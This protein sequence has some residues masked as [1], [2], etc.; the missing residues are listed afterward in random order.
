MAKILGTNRNIVLNNSSAE[1]GWGSK[2]LPSRFGS[3]FTDA[4]RSNQCM[5]LEAFKD[6][7]IEAQVESIDFDPT[8]SKYF[9][10]FQTDPQQANKM[11]EL[12]RQ[13][14]MKQLGKE[15]FNQ[16]LSGNQHHP[17]KKYRKYDFRMNDCELETFRARGFVVSERLGCNSFAEAYYRIYTDDLPVYVSA[18]SI[19][20][21]WHKTF[22][23]IIT[24]VELSF[25]IP[26]LSTMLD[27]MSN[28]LLALS[29]H[30][31]LLASRD[32]ADAFLCVAKSL[33]L[34]VKAPTQLNNDGKVQSIL[35]AIESENMMSFNLFGEERDMDFSQFKPRGHYT[36]SE[37]L[38]KYFKCMMW[39]GRVDFRIAGRDSSQTQLGC[40]IILLNLLLNSHQLEA[41]NK[42]NLFLEVFFGEVDSM[43]F[44]QLNDVLQ[45]TYQDIDTPN[46]SM[47]RLL[48]I[49]NVILNSNLGLQQ[50]QGHIYYTEIGGNCPREL[51]R[52]FTMTGQRF[53]LDSWLFS[54]VVMDEIPGQVPRRIPSCLDVAFGVFGNKNT[55]KELARRMEDSNGLRFR[56]GLPYHQN[57]VS[58]KQVIDSQPEE[59]WTASLYT[60][61]LDLLRELSQPAAHGSA[62]FHTESWHMKD[63]N[64]QMA[65]WTELRHD[66]ILYTKQAYARRAR[67]EYPEGFVEPRPAF[68]VL[69]ACSTSV[70]LLCVQNAVMSKF[71]PACHLGV[72]VF[73]MPTLSVEGCRP[74]SC[75]LRKFSKKRFLKTVMEEEFG[76]GG[77]RYLGWYPRL[78]HREREDSGKWD[79]VVADVHM[80]PVDPLLGDPGCILHE[81]VG[82]VFMALVAVQTSSGPS[83]YAGPVLSHYE[84]VTPNGERKNDAEWRSDIKSGAISEYPSWTTSY[85]VPGKLKGIEHFYHEDDMEDEW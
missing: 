35:D 82:N 41:W 23:C 34:G 53:S 27:G 55:A 2:P 15:K 16:I 77:T 70:S 13:K 19:L 6:Q 84:F 12:E 79:P 85:I 3:N 10:D 26:S 63:L 32:D 29:C 1:E 38:Q 8:E 73:H 57:L 64:T 44:I 69:T 47:G 22:D 24:D 31:D 67:C 42:F 76:S 83:M 9:E 52:S 36:S 50:I 61:W 74:M 37:E 78:F 45:T 71:S 33:I 30:D 56:D 51:P 48:E 62:T 49:Q 46:L 17:L 75:R 14:M 58:A 4:L 60:M 59:L 43:T 54:K 72:Q 28:A 18:D 80:D 21:A 7:F 65:S 81:G 68:W 39:L 40:A 5:T 66:S 11:N 20:H 25:C